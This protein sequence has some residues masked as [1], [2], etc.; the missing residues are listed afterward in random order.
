VDNRPPPAP[1]RRAVIVGGVRTPF[2]KAFAEYLRLDTIALGAAAVRGL[3]E[4][5]PV[6][7]REIGA[8][9]WGGVILP[10]LAPNVGRELALDLGL[11]PSVEA[12]TVTRACASGLQ[13]VTLAAA[14]IERG[15]HE[16]V[17]AGGSD[18]I[19]N[20]EVKLPQKVV[21][22]AAPLL[23]GKASAAA[24]LGLVG[25]L[26][27]LSEALP[28]AP[29][30]A[31]RTTGKLMGEAA[32]E[33]AR[34]NEISRAAQDEFA[35]RSHQRAARAIA[36]GRFG[37]EVVAVEAGGKVVQ[38]DTLVRPDTSLE[39]LAR[40]R[41]AFAPDGSVTAGNASPL[42]DGA[43]AVLLMSEAR[44]AALGVTPLASIASW[45]YVG[46]DPADQLLIGPALAMP[47]ALAR[48]GRELADMDLVDMHEAFAAQVLSV[49]K[50]LASPAFARLRLGRD[51]AVGELDPAR[52][53]VHGGSLALG[54][55]FAATG[56]RMVTTMANELHATGRSTALLGIC[57]A[58][59]L[60]AAAVLER[61]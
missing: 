5:H 16:V 44:A 59:G 51:R 48:A 20:A 35:L 40:L 11:D 34:R 38:T 23:T 8:V 57:A 56:A 46:V 39:K 31:E 27:P 17:I 10:G 22:A 21:H 6:P 25:Q 55:P 9:V 43:A 14:A 61:I 2:V 60:G 15:E 53:N 19:S 3:L 49:Q 45:A 1:G 7:R 29:R 52:L 47:L 54:H 28:R 24:V 32:E 42:T 37:A 18:S 33:M 26:F 36:T 13:A 4:R 12:M 50:A 30:V 58:G 41:P